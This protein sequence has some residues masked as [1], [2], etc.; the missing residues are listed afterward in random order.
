MN[1][2]SRGNTQLGMVLGKKGL[3]TFKAELPP[4]DPSQF[5][6]VQFMYN[7]MNFCIM[8][9]SARNGPKYDLYFLAYQN[10]PNYTLGKWF[11]GTSVLGPA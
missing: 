6:S 1:K 11:G 10:G 2:F 7:G 9:H 3:L 4:N 8:H 5:S